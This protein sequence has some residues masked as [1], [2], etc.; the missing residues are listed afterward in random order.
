MYLQ[1]SNDKFYF[2][3]E[4]GDKVKALKDG[5][6]HRRKNTLKVIET[7]QISRFSS[8]TQP[9]MR[10]HQFLYCYKIPKKHKYPTKIMVSEREIKPLKITEEMFIKMK[11]EWAAKQM[12]SILLQE[13]G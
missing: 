8:I 10:P 3:Y 1:K 6:H 11:E 5:P 4:K 13:N 7:S 9:N 2:V 12:K